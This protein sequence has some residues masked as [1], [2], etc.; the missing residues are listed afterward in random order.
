MTLPA[1]SSSCSSSWTRMH[2]LMGK[3]WRRRRRRR[4]MIIV[5][6]T[7]LVMVMMMILMMIVMMLMKT[8]H[9]NAVTDAAP[10]TDRD[11]HT[12]SPPTHTTP[13]PNPGLPW[14]TQIWPSS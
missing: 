14:V 2:S 11:T 13:E 6:M 8:M 1:V 7:V 5:L 3:A 4:M 9:P 12:Q 10:V